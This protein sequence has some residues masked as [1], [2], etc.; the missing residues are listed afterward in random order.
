MVGN[1]QHLECQQLCMDIPVDIQ[2]ASFM[3]DLHVLPIS[4][5]NIV[6]GVQWLQ[7]LGPILT[8]YNSFCMQ[9]FHQGRIVELKGE[10][11]TSLRQLSSP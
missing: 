11:D 9:F 10:N 3:V 1:G 6:L 7:S 5:A 4:R 2:T 8:D